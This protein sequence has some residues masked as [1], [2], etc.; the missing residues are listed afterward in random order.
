MKAIPWLFVVAAAAAEHIFVEQEWMF[1]R[2]Y[3]SRVFTPVSFAL[4]SSPASSFRR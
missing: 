1:S 4:S 2:R 3:H